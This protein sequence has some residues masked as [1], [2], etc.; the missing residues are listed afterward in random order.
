MT[1]VCKFVICIIVFINWSLLTTR[2]TSSIDFK[3]RHNPSP[4]ALELNSCSVPGGQR[5]PKH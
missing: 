3:F 1:I 4:V 2:S 5:T